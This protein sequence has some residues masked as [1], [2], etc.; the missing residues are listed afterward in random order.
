MQINSKTHKVYA[1]GESGRHVA[2]DATNLQV[3]EHCL[4]I[5][6][7]LQNVPVDR[8]VRGIFVKRNST[9]GWE[10]EQSDQ[11]NDITLNQL[12]PVDR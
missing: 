3:V 2:I 12:R 9:G 7:K 11:Q 4:S 5:W 6:H 10:S 1:L 8:T